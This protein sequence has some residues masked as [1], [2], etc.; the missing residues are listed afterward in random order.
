MSLPYMN[1]MGLKVEDRVTGFTGVVTSVCYDLYGCIQVA[2]NPGTSPD[3][4]LD[5]GRWFDAKRIKVLNKKP[6]ME[7]PA[8]AS[9]PLLARAGDENGPAEK[10][11]SRSMP[12]R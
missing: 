2:L 10:P 3:G 4:K 1:L 9:E 6:V 11:A 12:I 7:I 8:F 5:D